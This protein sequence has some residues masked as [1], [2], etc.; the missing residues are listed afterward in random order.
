MKLTCDQECCATD[1][2][3]SEGRTE[4]SPS[5]D[6]ASLD[7]T[8]IQ[9][10]MAHVSLNHDLEA[11]NNVPQILNDSAAARGWRV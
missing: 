2:C 11:E 4:K 7:P 8:T 5:W 10:K 1:F 9:C 6:C 3:F